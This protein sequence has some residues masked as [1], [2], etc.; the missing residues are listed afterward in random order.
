[1]VPEERSVTKTVRRSVPRPSEGDLVRAV[2]LHLEGQGYRVRIDP[3]GTDYFDLVA[4]RGNEVGLV[5][6]KVVGSRAVLAQALK[7]RGWG[8]WTAVALGSA[9]AAERLARRTT[10]TRAEPVGVWSVAGSSVRVHR[11][12][13]AWADAGGADPFRPLRDRFR[14]LLDAID[15]GELPEAARW[16]GVP[17]AVRRASGGRGFSEW[18]LDEPLPNER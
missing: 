7:R 10:A 3:D 12:A 14:R 18:R 6:A 5:E 13:R 11:P 15:A 8:D 2:A 16:D 4:R 9:I 1:V 17:R